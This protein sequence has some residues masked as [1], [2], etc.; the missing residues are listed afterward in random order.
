MACMFH[1]PER[2]YLHHRGVRLQHRGVHLH[3]RG[4][5]L[6]YRGV[7]LHHRGVSLHHRGVSLH[8]RGVSLHHR[9]ARS[10][11]RDTL[12]FLFLVF[13]A[14][15]EILICSTC[16]IPI[17]PESDPEMNYRICDVKKKICMHTKNW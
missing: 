7:R 11:H 2:Y 1:R 6:H 3:H 10:H 12:L 16:I 9:D 13:N 15:S 4:V 5:R 8:H 14:S 17:N